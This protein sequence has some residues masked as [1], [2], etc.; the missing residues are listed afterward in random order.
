MTKKNKKGEKEKQNKVN[1]P[2]CQD[3]KNLTLG[4]YC[5]CCG[6]GAYTPWNYPVE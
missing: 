3:G 4:E 5:A 2:K 1:C 6:Y